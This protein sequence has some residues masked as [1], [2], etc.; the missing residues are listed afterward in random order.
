MAVARCQQYDRYIKPNAAVERLI[1]DVPVMDDEALYERSLMVEPRA[2]AGP[3]AASKIKDLK[4]FLSNQT[5]SSS[6]F[7]A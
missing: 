2:S 7:H 4:T 1:V 3:V 5:Y 6:S